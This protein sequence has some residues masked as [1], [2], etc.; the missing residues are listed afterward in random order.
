MFQI[1]ELVFKLGSTF[2]VLVKGDELFEESVIISEQRGNGFKEGLT[3]FRGDATE[4][5]D[6]EVDME[7]SVLFL[8]GN[9]LHLDIQL[10]LLE[11]GRKLRSLSI[12]GRGFTNF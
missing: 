10:T 11:D 5:Q 12:E 8:E 9:K 7:F 1:Y 2:F 3:P 4:M 6:D